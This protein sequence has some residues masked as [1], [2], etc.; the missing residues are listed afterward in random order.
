MAL[1]RSLSLGC[2]MVIS[3]GFNHERQ[4]WKLKSDCLIWQFNLAKMNRFSSISFPYFPQ[5]IMISWSKLAGT[6]ISESPASLRFRPVQ[7]NPFGAGK[8]RKVLTWECSWSLF[9]G[10]DDRNLSPMTWDIQTGTQTWL[11]GIS[12]I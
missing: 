10:Y 9:F 1:S 12:S 3:H 7:T 6:I 5:S 8:F 4:S 11:A 2:P